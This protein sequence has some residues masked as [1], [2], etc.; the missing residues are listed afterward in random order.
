MSVKDLCDEC[1]NY[2]K[3][4]RLVIKGYDLFICEDCFGND[5]NSVV[6]A[7]LHIPSIEV[8]EA[9]NE[10]AVAILTFDQYY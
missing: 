6:A 1:N 4:E 10:V 3:G 5:N 9:Y 8:S 2:A 7:K